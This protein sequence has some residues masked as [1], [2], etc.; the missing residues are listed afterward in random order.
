M[1]VKYL[2]WKREVK[3]SGRAIA[4]EEVRGELAQEKLYMQGYDR[5]GRPLVYGFGARH[6]PARRDLDE[7]KRYVV[8]VLDRTCARLGGN[9]GQEKFAAVADLQGWGYYGNC[10]IRAYVAALE[11][12]Q[13][14][15]PE[16]LG[17]VFLIHVPYV[18][19]AAWKII[20]PF[21]DDNTKKKF[22]FVA[23]KDLHATLRDAIDDSNLAEDYG[24]KLK[25]VSPLINGATES[26]RRR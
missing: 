4:D 13:N 21:I 15:Y 18:F 22:V 23:D 5:Q 12:M 2:Q 16:R 1:L 24:G 11:I 26:N 9:G 14:Y 17:R 7:F 3:P 19:M 6:F 8:Y 25:L 20:Y 10:D